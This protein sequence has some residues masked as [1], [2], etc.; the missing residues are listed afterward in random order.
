M[1]PLQAFFGFEGPALALLAVT[2]AVVL[3][4]LLKVAVAIAI[5]VGIVAAVVFGILFVLNVL[6]D[7]N[8]LGLP[9]ATF[10]DATQFLL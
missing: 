6:F 9:G 7:F 4:L 2:V 1:I 3:F 10:V 5:R 8:P